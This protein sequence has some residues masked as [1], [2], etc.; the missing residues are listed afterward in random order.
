MLFLDLGK[1]S[2]TTLSLELKIIVAYKKNT[3][4]IIKKKVLHDYHF[5]CKMIG[6]IG[7]KKIQSKQSII[8]CEKTI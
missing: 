4:L 3:A 2:R 6:D 7:M 5:A 1:L 8:T